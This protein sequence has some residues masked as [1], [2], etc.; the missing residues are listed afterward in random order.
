MRP[1]DGTVEQKIAELAARSHG[2]VTRAELLRAGLTVDEIRRRLRS[3]HSPA[4]VPGRLPRRPPRSQS[5][6]ALPGRGTRLW[7]GGAA[8]RK[9]AA[10][11]LGVLKGAPPPPEVIAPVARR[12]AGVSTRRVRRLDQR[13]A[14]TWRAIP[15]DH[16][17]TI[18]DLAA[19]LATVDL[20]RACHEAGVRHRTT[21]AMV[22]DVLAR[23]PNSPG[24]AKLR[25][26]LRGDVR[27]TLSRL[28]SRFLERLRDRGSCSP[29]P[30]VPPEAGA[31]IAA[32]L[33][34]VSPSNLTVTAITTLAT[35]GS[36]TVAGARGPRP[37]RRLRRYTYGDVFEHPRFMLAELR[38]LL[39]KS[40]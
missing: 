19:V 18:V 26:V 37:R 5:R 34:S 22:E 32:G 27:V 8:E 7:R 9:A 12:V 23:R 30:T 24:A 40:R 13:D 20:A 29:R 39:P 14:T 15:D 33:S 25:E 31:S 17:R 11:L 16:P 10:H 21:P 38:A 2:V 35:P 6:G 28:E 4:R 3:A 1:L 36:R